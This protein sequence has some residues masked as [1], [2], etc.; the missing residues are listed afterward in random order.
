MPNSSIKN[1]GN[2]AVIIVIVL[3][4]LLVAGGGG[5]YLYTKFKEEE[6]N[7]TQIN[8]YLDKERDYLKKELDFENELVT[9]KDEKIISTSKAAIAA[10]DELQKQEIPEFFKKTENDC[11]EARMKTVTSIKYISNIFE[12]ANATKTIPS[13]YELQKTMDEIKSIKDIN[14]ID[15]RVKICKEAREKSKKEAEKYNIEISKKEDNK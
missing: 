7:I 10:W 2:T 6:K 4:V 14:K 11:T 1:K 12:K 13:Q 8:S 3:L 9:L 5:Y 15:E